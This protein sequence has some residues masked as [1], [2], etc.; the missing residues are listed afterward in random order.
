MITLLLL[1]ILDSALSAGDRPA[2]FIDVAH[3]TYPAA[4]YA[5]QA[6]RW[7]AVAQSDCAT[8]ADHLEYFLAARYANRFADGI[9]EIDQV[10]NRAAA[11]LSSDSFALNYMRYVHTVGQERYRYLKAAYAIKPEEPY[12]QASMLGFAVLRGD[13]TL[14]ARTSRQLDR[15]NPHP[16]GLM[17]YSYNM[18]HSVAPGGL[19]LT[20]GDADTY[21]AWILQWVHGVRAD[22]LL[23]NYNQ[24]SHYPDYARH[25]LRT[26]GVEGEPAA[27]AAARLQQLRTANRPLHIASTAGDQLGELGIPQS[28]MYALGLV[29]RVSDTPVETLSTTRRLYREVWRLD[30]L[31]N[32]LG[33]S[34]A[35]QAALELSPNYLIPLIELLKQNQAGDSAEPDLHELIHTIAHRNQLTKRVAA[36]LGESAGD[37]PQL[38]S[39]E[40]GVDVKYLL[41]RYRNGDVGIRTKYHERTELM[42]V[43]MQETETTNA[44]YALFLQDLLRQRKFD[45]LD[46]AAIEP[47]DWKTL[48]PNSITNLDDAQVY[49]NGRPE[50]ANHPILNISHRAAELYAIWLTQAYNQHPKRKDTREVR[51]R[52]P[53]AQEFELAARGGR[54]HA[55]YPWGGPYYYNAKGC[56]LGNLNVALIDDSYPAGDFAGVTRGKSRKQKSDPGCKLDGAYVTTPVYHYY[57][58]NYGLYNMAGNAAEMTDVDGQ[59]MGGSWLD[60]PEALKNGVITERTLPSP[61]TGFRLVMEYVE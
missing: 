28:D 4:Y 31:R 50:D 25:V 45:Y 11:R 48:L 21:P 42:E 24:F 3:G 38:A 41:A 58:N 56:I 32:P 59:T 27:N 52:L 47:M 13:S 61:T 10:V 6:L 53:T 12:V 54:E 14:A 7:Q 9:Y 1:L 5:E 17:D 22:V 19:L 51:F 30:I 55:P 15:L 2:P 36:L 49:R 18:L 60:G 44:E 35:T 40:A 39:Q 33:S 37:T 34:P 29:F 26:V 43:G 57:P 23:V 20:F 46:T 16:T 8:E